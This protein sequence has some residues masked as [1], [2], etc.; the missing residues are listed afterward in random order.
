MSISA[1][2]SFGPSLASLGSLGSAA[3]APAAG[4]AAGLQGGVD[5]ALKALSQNPI[6]RSLLGESA[7][8]GVQGAGKTGQAAQA[9]N[10]QEMLQKVLDTLKQLVSVL[11]TLSGQKTGGEGGQKAGC[12]EGGQ[13]AGCGEGAKGGQQAGGAQGAQG[14]QG[15]EAEE[16]QDPIQKLLKMLE[17]IMQAISQLQQKLGGGQTGTQSA[18]PTGGAQAPTAP[19]AA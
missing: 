18:A 14:A 5:Q 1:M 7:F 2:K 8:D 13:K 19:A 3:P 6:V 9:S 4:N 11:E 16:S 17:Q 15:A 10:P 12:G